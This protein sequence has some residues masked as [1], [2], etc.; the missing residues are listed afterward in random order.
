MELLNKKTGI[1]SFLLLFSFNLS[2][3]VN[4]SQI[5]AES[6]RYESSGDYEK[7]IVN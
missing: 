6:Y 4:P 2:A 7:A 3:Q 5:F 1:I